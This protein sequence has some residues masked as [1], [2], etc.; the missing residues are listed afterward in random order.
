MAW[1]TSGKVSSLNDNIQATL[2]TVE[3]LNL[4]ITSLST[5]QGEFKN[6]QSLL[7]EAVAKAE[8]SVIEMQEK[9][10]NVA[11][12]KVKLETDKV[13]FKIQELE[14]AL[15]DQGSDLGRVSGVVS[16]L[17]SQL[18][19]FENRLSNIQQLSEDVESLV[20]LEKEKY[21]QVLERQA[22]LQEKQSD[23][24]PIKVPRDP[25]MV[26]YSISSE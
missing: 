15:K 24:N 6:Q 12:Q 1:Q 18:Q 5:N 22:D 7:G 21:L 11:A 20:I 2:E 4:T 19:N 14:K 10:P 16:T 9:L 3:E 13:I 8:G 26:F 25:N 23:R 17:G